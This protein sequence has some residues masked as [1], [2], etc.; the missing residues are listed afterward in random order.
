MNQLEIPAHVRSVRS[1]GAGLIWSGMARA[2]IIDA[3]LK[4]GAR[5]WF[6]GKANSKTLT[7]L[8]RCLP[9]PCGERSWALFADRCA[10]ETGTVEKRARASKPCRATGTLIG[11]LPLHQDPRP[12]AG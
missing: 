8:H 10:V 3:L 1:G 7:S 2:K 12:S 11:K 6:P 5:A 4:L 9:L